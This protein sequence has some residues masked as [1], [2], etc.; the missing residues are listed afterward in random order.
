[1]TKKQINN[2]IQIINEYLNG[3]FISYSFN[4]IGT[5][6]QLKVW[7]EVMKIP[8][9]KTETYKQIADKI[10][11]HPRAVARAVASNN[12]PVTV[13]CHRVIGTDRKLHGFKW[14]LDLKRKLLAHEGVKIE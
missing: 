14:G 9:G 4:L 11:S 8:K 1:M 6:F 10:S 5:D 3:N 13:P 7:R 2:P 12:Y